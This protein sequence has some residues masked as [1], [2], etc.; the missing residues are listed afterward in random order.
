[1]WNNIVKTDHVTF[2]SPSSLSS[3]SHHH[4]HVA[5]CELCLV[6]KIFVDRYGVS[7]SEEYQASKIKSLIYTF[8]NHSLPCALMQRL[9]THTHCKR[10]TRTSK[11]QHHI[12]YKGFKL[13]VKLR[14][15]IPSKPTKELTKHPALRQEPQYFL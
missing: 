4:R 5:E 15:T 8:L 11:T 13:E 2:F 10:C 6:L 9:M 7:T 14:R 1:M 3:I 12:L